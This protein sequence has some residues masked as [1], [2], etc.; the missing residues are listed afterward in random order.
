MTKGE[1]EF[2]DDVHNLQN[3]KPITVTED[4]HDEIS[5]SDFYLITKKPKLS[6]WKPRKMSYK[7]QSP[8]I[9]PGS[10]ISLVPFKLI[11]YDP[12]KSF[13]FF[14]NSKPK[15]K[16]KNRVSSKTSNKKKSYLKV[17]QK[18]MINK[19]SKRITTLDNI[20]VSSS[21]N[22][23]SENHSQTSG[24]DRPKT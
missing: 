10:K 20:S 6:N 24:F 9:K 21:E 22:S 15:N 16:T 5:K 1:V 8:D 18:L 3:Y 7:M 17:P 19:S 4:E 23:S 2:I 11:Q 14:L 12:M 13:G